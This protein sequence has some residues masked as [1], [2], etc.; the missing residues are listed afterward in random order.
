MSVHAL[1]IKIKKHPKKI[2]I[3]LPENAQQKFG[4]WR[5]DE[6]KK[7]VFAKLNEA[8]RKRRKQ[9]KLELEEADSDETRDE[10]SRRFSSI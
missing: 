8:E 10:L 2:K 1:Q 6:P 4:R 5:N 9:A 7:S 3:L